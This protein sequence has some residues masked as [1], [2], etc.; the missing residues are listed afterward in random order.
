M[1]QG[2]G[3]AVCR[4]CTLALPLSDFE[5]VKDLSKP[6]GL[7]RVTTCRACVERQDRDRLLRKRYGITLDD[8]EAMERAQ[9]G[10]CAI[11]RKPPKD[12]ALAVD[13]DH[14][15]GLVRGLLCIFCNHRLLGVTDD[16]DH[17]AAA[18][19]YL[20]EPPADKVLRAQ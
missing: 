14:R 7:R 6:T 4:R 20:R 18:A 13:H 15:T 1:T 5:E 10:R 19:A 3:V 2:Q 8:Y 16:P 9:D 12:K 11:C 17:L